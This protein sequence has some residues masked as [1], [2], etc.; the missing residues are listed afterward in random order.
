MSNV[1]VLQIKNACFL[2]TFFSLICPF[3]F[4]VYLSLSIT[5]THTYT[6]THTHTHTKRKHSTGSS[7]HNI[8]WIFL[9]F[10]SIF[11][12]YII[13]WRFFKLAFAGYLSRNSDS[14]SLQIFRTLH[15]ILDD[16]DNAVV[17]MAWILSFLSNSS[18]LFCKS[19]DTIPRA[20]TII[21]IILCS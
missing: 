5:H 13:T 20:P 4:M 18:I 17:S 11:V 12:Q 9:V 19:L 10:L 15:S 16:F 7:A 14:N 6:H 8:K 21:G 1:K 2:S 3:Y